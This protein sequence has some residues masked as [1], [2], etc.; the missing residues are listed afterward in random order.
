M[1]NKPNI[2]INTAPISVDHET[3]SVVSRIVEEYV[4]YF[5]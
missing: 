2:S 3:L 5:L 1:Y 4:R